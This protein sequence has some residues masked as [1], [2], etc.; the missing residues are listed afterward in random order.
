MPTEPQAK[1]FNASILFVDISGFTNFTEKFVSKYGSKGLEQVAIHINSYFS[2]IIEVIYKHSGD[3][4]K[5][6]GD[7]LICLFGSPLDPSHNLKHLTLRAIRCALDI[8]TNCS[9][10][11]HE[12]VA[13][14]LHLGISS[15]MVTGLIVGGVDNCWEWLIAGRCLR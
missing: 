3:I 8:Q 15:G 4:V 2:Q 12:D 11:Q 10:Y 7:A 1:E 9:R 13:L 6:A 5:F 14:T